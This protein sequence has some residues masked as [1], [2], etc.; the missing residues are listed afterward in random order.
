MDLYRVAVAAGNITQKFPV[1][2]VKEFLLH[3]DKDFKKIIP[4]KHEKNLI[5]EV[6]KLTKNIREHTKD[7]DKRLKWA[8]KVLT[9]RCRL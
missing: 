2:S 5:N 6:R 8:E 1:E 9:V 3:I 4:T 7:P